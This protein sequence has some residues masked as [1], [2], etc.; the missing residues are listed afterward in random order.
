LPTSIPGHSLITLAIR[1]YDGSPDIPEENILFA[2][3]IEG[4]DLDRDAMQRLR[5]SVMDRAIKHLM[6]N[7]Y[8]SALVRE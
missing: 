1:A 3:E 6:A 7:W 4:I 2:E 8:L 5:E